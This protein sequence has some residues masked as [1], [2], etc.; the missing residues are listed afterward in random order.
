M[1]YIGHNGLMEFSVDWPAVNGTENPKPDTIVLCCISQRYFADSLLSAG[2]KPLLMT[3]QLMYP[4]AFILHDALEPWLAG[5][6]SVMREKA[7]LA[8]SKNQKI[9]V[10]AAKGVFAAP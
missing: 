9:S 6:P 10:K 8:Y 1:A 5:D 7:A 2:S 4:G 3:T